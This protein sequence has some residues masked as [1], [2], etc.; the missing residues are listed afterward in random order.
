GRRQHEAA[1]ARLWLRSHHRRRRPLPVDRGGLDRGEGH[2]RPADDRRRAGLSRLRLRKPHGLF[3]ATAFRSAE[4]ARAVHASPAKLRAGARA[5]ARPRSRQLEARPAQLSLERTS[6]IAF[7]TS[8][9]PVA[10]FTL[11]ARIF[12][13]AAT[14][15]SAERA[16]TSCKA[17]VSAWAIFCSAK[18]VR[19]ATYSSV[20]FLA[21]AESASASRR[22]WSM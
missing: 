9:A 21:S 4:S 18:R 2:A 15:T 10:P 16:R 13:A 22:A 20:R 8:S 3:D 6:P 14:A 19:P 11:A 17:C 7:S 12:S 5:A 1:G